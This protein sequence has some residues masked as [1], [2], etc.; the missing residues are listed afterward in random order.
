M[1]I[2][3]VTR[4]EVF[5]R[6]HF[7]CFYCGRTPP[8]VCLQVDHIVPIAKGGK[9][10]IENLVT[11]CF[12]CNIGKGARKL[13]RTPVSLQKKMEEIDEKREQIKKYES[14]LKKIQRT[15]EK[16]IA[17]VEKVFQKHFPGFWFEER[18]KFSVG[19]FISKLPVAVVKEAMNKA[20]SVYSHQEEAC[21]Y[22][23][24]ICWKTIREGNNGLD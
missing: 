11:S 9:D 3:K 21:T 23:G 14:M 13:S 8:E 15:K 24:G 2:K 6:D 22:F 7:K 5:K 12:D 20:C 16:N 4:F 18:F 19:N 1:S 17:E 10:I